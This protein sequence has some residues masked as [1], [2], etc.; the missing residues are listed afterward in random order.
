M[1]YIAD[2]L[3]YKHQT[4]LQIEQFEHLWVDVKVKGK[5]YAVNALYRPST[6]TSS[7]EYETFL[8]A[9]DN[10]LSRLTNHSAD[11]N[12]FLSDMNFGNCYSKSP[13]LTPKPLDSFAPEL[14]QSF[15]FSQVIDIPTR[16]TEQTTS[17]IDLI[18]VSCIDNITSHGT[19][20]KIADHDGIFITF[21]CSQEKQKP[22]T[23]IVYDYSNVDQ[24]GLCKF[25]NSVDFNNIV[26]SKPLSQ[27]AELFTDILTT[28]FSKFVPCKTVVFRPRDQPW[29]NTYTRLLLRK[30]NRN[31]QLFKQANSNYLN[32]CNRP[33]S[34]PETITR[35][36]DKKTRASEKS[37]ESSN[38]SQ[39]A[40]KRAK[41]NFYNCVNSTMNNPHISP[42]KK[43]SI[44]TRL[45]KNN[46]SSSVPPLI[47]DF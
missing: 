47:E 1:I 16:V 36:L 46:K 32:A 23:K 27:Q 19:L 2:H 30:K 38:Q 14:F 22:K 45:L 11:T 39:Y 43:F 8:A 33:L 13:I 31:Y 25:I 5:I 10:V 26:F 21:Q 42:K 6:Q 18:F 9:S 34:T 4:S 24:D 28:A 20:G 17:L 12:V 35:L 29:T 41:T 40:N 44:L 37:R 3:T 7:E 15:G